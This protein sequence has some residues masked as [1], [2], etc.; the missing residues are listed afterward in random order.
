MG[1]IPFLAQNDDENIG[2]L[3]C[4]WHQLSI[5]RTHGME[6]NILSVVSSLIS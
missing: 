6:N 4:S 5:L 2:N 3:N 1:C